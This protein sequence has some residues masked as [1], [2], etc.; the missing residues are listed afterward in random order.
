MARLLPRM[1]LG[2]ALGV[3]VFA[4]AMGLLDRWDAPSALVSL[5]AAAGAVAALLGA[6]ARRG[7][8]ALPAG[9]SAPGFLLRAAGWTLGIFVLLA[10]VFW[11]L[12]IRHVAATW[13]DPEH[14]QAGLFAVLVALWYGGSWA[15]AAGA[16]LAWRATPRP[17]GQTR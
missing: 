12:G 7:A 15:P 14:S 2:L 13:P 4:T 6:A 1:V 8:L 3:A 10:P 5:A 9:A 16:W 17:Q 11:G